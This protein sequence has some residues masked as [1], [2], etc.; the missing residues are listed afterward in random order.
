MRR[1]VVSIAALTAMLTAT[2]AHASGWRI[3]EQS[4]DSISKASA[5]IASASHP[6]AAYYNPANMG[7]LE[8]GWQIEGAF[9]YLHLTA[10]DYED[11]RTPLYN[12]SS[13]KEHFGLPVL[14]VVS[15]KYNNCRFG[16]ALTA[17]YGLS[18]RWPDPYPSNFAK[19]F[20]LKVFEAN[21][22][23][24]Y[25]FGDKVAISGGLRLLYGD[26]EVEN[27]GVV[28]PTTGTYALRN[29]NGD[30]LAWGYNLAVAVKPS[31][32]WNISATYRSQVDQDFDGD[33]R[34]FTN[35]GPTDIHTDGS[36]TVP[37]P[38]VLS[39]SV[40]YT[41]EDLTV[42]LTWDRTYWGKYEGLDFDYTTPISNPLLYMLYDA[43]V[44]KDWQD[45]SAYR[46][47]LEYRVSDRFTLLGGF[48]YDET[49][50]PDEHLSFE[51]PDA[52][53]YLYSLGFRYRVNERLELGVGALYDSKTARRVCNTNA[54]GEFTN[55]A[56]LLLTFGATYTF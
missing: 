28:D 13:A 52:D 11:D 8:D 33:A 20:T 14:F 40:A 49:P 21:P 55:A 27:A 53:A 15:P 2:S 39:L 35:L 23:I 25:T 26:A 42:D 54:C 50:A 48:A 1:T 3:P 24:S 44:V 41:W 18:K 45:A 56:A 7:W 22:T 47:G 12:G 17:P 34:L 19:D 32:D 10:T 36:V 43:P 9:T 46:L 51:L 38:A 5:N 6:D 16:F 37:A 30:S 31:P 4:L 29:I